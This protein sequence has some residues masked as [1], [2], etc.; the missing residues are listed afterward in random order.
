[1]FDHW[2]DWVIVSA[3]L[4]Y[5]LG[6]SVLG[7]IGVQFETPGSLWMWLAPPAIAIIVVFLSGNH[8]V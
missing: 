7:R 6:P 8:T 1:M 5:F 2:A 3:M 4:W